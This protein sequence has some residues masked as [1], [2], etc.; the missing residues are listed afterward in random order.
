MI[1]INL[2]ELT[3]DEILHWPPVL[4]YSMLIVFA[5]L[6]ALLNY[7][8]VLSSNLDRYK[9]LAN[10]KINLERV[11]ERKQP[12]TNLQAYQ[13]QLHIIRKMYGTGLKQLVKENE[14]SNF[15]NEI[16]QIALSTGVVIEFFTP[17]IEDKNGRKKELIIKIEVAGEYHKLALFLS[18][19]SDLDKLI[20]FDNFKV[21]VEDINSTVSNLLRMQIK[22]KIH[23]YYK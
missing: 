5:I 23:R 13:K 21:F 16:S 2:N 9:S 11:Y 15:L 12:F 20:T 6:L 18:K 4:R 7:G 1:R 17:K 8:L 14:I 3:L 22:A 19:I 10:E